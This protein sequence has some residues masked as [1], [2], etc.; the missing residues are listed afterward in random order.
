MVFNP[1]ASSVS[2]PVRDVIAHALA[3]EVKLDVAETK[4]RHHATELAAGAVADGFDLIAC[5]GGDGTLNEVVNGMAGA[6]V[7]VI[8]LPGGGTNVFAR[9]MGLP[10]D[11]VEATSLVLERLH[12]DVEPERINLGRVNGRAFTFCAGIGFDAA[13][14]R[15][16]E[17]R[18]RIKRR[19]GEPFFVYQAVRTFFFAYPRRNPPLS[20]EAGEEA[21]DGLHQVVV[22]NSN[23]YTF[24]GK[25]PFQLCPSASSDRGLDYTALRSFRTAT[26]L[27]VVLRAFGAAGHPKMR[28]VRTAHDLDEF[29]VHASRPVLYQVDGDFAG[30]ASA[31]ELSSEPRA[32]SV[33]C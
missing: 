9:T 1:H 10:K 32:L 19:V 24:L 3:S 2:E 4:H 27:R 13:V 20:I 31:F 14:V 26:V 22:C 25:R 18:Q 23:P 33:I 30:E 15:A 28:S 21:V 6:E 8:P 16:V 29:R 17:R 5:L 7:P 11:P 12:D